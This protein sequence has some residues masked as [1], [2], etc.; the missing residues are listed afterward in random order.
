MG[1]TRWTITFIN[2]AVVSCLRV[3]MDWTRRM[4]IQKNYDVL[5]YQDQTISKMKRELP[6]GEIKWPC[7]VKASLKKQVLLTEN[8]SNQNH[9]VHVDC[10]LH[11]KIELVS[12]KRKA[13]FDV[14]ERPSKV[15]NTSLAET[16]N[17]NS[18]K[19]SGV[20]KINK[21]S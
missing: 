8:K 18:I 3:T 17:T 21:L 2:Q 4:Y 12:K 6:P 7:C 20:K 5:M 16:E 10:K 11:R 9:E 1:I 19:V 14:C 15:L 13:T